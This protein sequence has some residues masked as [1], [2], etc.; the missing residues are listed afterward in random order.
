MCVDAGVP[1]G[2]CQRFVLPVGDVLLCLRVPVLLRQAEI[3]DVYLVGLLAQ[4]DQ[5]VVRL[6]VAVDEALSVEVL[7]SLHQ[8]AEECARCRLGK[9]APHGARHRS[10]EF[11]ALVEVQ[12][13]HDAVHIGEEVEGPDDVTVVQLAERVKLA[14]HEPDH[15]FVHGANDLHGDLPPVL[16]PHG[17]VHNTCGALI[18]RIHHIVALG[19]RVAVLVP[20]HVRACRRRLG[21]ADGERQ[22][23]SVLALGFCGRRV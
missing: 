14:P 3:D 20:R 15:L 12:N 22:A 21:A 6:D 1:R 7:Y 11:N 10:R 9:M 16:L 5:E 13:E 2:A 4:P 17:L 19:K 8:S 23:E 18:D